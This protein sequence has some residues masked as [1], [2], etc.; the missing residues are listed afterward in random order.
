MFKLYVF[1]V[2]VSHLLMWINCVCVYIYIYMN[3]LYMCIYIYFF[4]LF[5]IF[6][7]SFLW[8]FFTINAL[9]VWAKLLYVFYL[10]FTYPRAKKTD[11]YQRKV[12]FA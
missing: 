5:Y 2:R 8:S 4:L 10:I 7:C 11:T 1:I 9:H 12:Y 3:K 6:V